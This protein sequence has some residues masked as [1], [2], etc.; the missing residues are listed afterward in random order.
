MLFYVFSSSVLFSSAAGFR[1]SQSPKVLVGFT[2][3]SRGHI[4]LVYDRS[5]VF[6][7]FLPLWRISVQSS[8]S[9]VTL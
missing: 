2:D 6:C 9:F 1:Q 3:G 4:V 5:A 7:F 8:S